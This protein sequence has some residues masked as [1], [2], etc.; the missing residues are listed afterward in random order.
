MTLK[1]GAGERAAPRGP[2]REQ[3][4]EVWSLRVPRAVCGVPRDYWGPDG[5]RS[6]E[7]SRVG[8]QHVGET[9]ADS[10]TRGLREPCRT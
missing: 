2:L 9:L 8:R 6:F 10:R 1:C 3:R 4:A 5:G 7:T